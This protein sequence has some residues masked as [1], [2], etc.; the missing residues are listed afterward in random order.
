MLLSFY[1][2]R[3]SSDSVS[4]SIAFNNLSAVTDLSQLINQDMQHTAQLVGA[5]ASLPG[6]VESMRLHDEEA[7][8]NRLRA[9]ILTYPYINR[10]FVTDAN[11]T[12]WRDYPLAPFTLGK[13][14]DEEPWFHTLQTAGGIAISEAYLTPLAARTPVVTVATAVR[15]ENGEMLGTMA[16]EYDLHQVARW[17]QNIRIAHHGYLYVLDQTG[18]TIAHPDVA[19]G[20][21]LPDYAALPQINR[22]LAGEWLSEEYIDPLA[23]LRMIATF[24]PLSVGS[25]RWVIVAQQPVDEAYASLKDV[26]WKISFAGGLL[27]L[28][29]LGMIAALAKMRARNERLN[30]ELAEA[31]QSLKDFTSIVSHQLRAPLTAMGMT[32]ELAVDGDF[33]DVNPDL[34]KELTTMQDVTRQGQQLISDILNVSRLDRGVIAAETH[35]IKLGEIAEAAVRNYREP[36]KAAGLALTIEG[37]GEIVIAGDKDKS[38]EAVANSVSNAIKHT[39]AGGITLKM[40]K[41]AECGTIEVSD[42]G[43]GMPP[44]ILGKLFSRDGIHGSNTD[45]SASTGLGLYIAKNFMQLQGGDVWAT[46]ELGKGSVFHYRWKLQS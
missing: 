21:L 12:V 13:T 22:A 33:G 38:A 1:S 34:K 18:T 4:Q 45:P 29:T 32:L 9:L 23:K 19:T 16:F 15:G 37:D 39:K 44:E 20:A 5:V 14:M 46:A 43:E 31:N 41:D 6:T 3:V 11:G 36:M 40:W 2:Y 7:I 24:Q 8:G 35:P 27:T 30:L 10:A 26:R 25:Q 42:T 28:L 17:L